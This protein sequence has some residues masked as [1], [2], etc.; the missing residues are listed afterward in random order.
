MDF[1]RMD[2]TTNIFVNETNYQGNSERDNLS[3]KSIINFPKKTKEKNLNWEIN[4]IT[5]NQF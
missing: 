3:K 4:L 2:Y 5:Q 1:Y